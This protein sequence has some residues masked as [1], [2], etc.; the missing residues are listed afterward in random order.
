M[1]G[2]PFFTLMFLIMFLN[3]LFNPVFVP[4]LGDPFFTIKKE[5]IKEFRKDLF[6][7]PCL[8]ILFSR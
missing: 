1:L 7:S 5:E 3:E 4:M 2:D 8:G 6:S